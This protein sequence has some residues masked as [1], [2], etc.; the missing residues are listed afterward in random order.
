MN[1]IIWGINA[2][3]HDAAISVINSNGDILFAAHSE[4][5]SKIK[6]DGAI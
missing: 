5:Y 6:N 3:S 1:D 2:L 4:R